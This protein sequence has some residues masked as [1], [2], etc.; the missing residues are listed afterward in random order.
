MLSQIEDT[1]GALKE[2]SAD[3]LAALQ[4]GVVVVGS[5]LKEPSADA[6]AALQHGKEVVTDVVSDKITHR[7]RQEQQR[8]RRAGFVRWLPL[9]AVLV[10]VAVWVARRRVR[11]NEQPVLPQEA[12]SM[13]EPVD[14]RQQ[15]PDPL[16]RAASR[17]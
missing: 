11:Q 12:A 16:A 9:V 5:A 8:R 4:H 1:L 17:A 6:L 15:A 2:P 3:A 10:L 14:Q 13:R 7:Q